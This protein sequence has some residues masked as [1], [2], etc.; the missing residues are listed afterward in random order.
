MTDGGRVY[1][2]LAFLIVTL[3]YLSAAGSE[4]FAF[5]K[6]KIAYDKFEW[7][8]YRSTHFEIYFY[9]EEEKALQKVV[10]FAESAYDDLA[11]KFNFQISDRIPLIYYAT[12]SD[13]EQ[14][15]VILMFIPEGVGAFAEPAKNRMVLPIDMPDEELLELITHELTH[16]FEYEIL[17]QGR[18]GREITN[19]LPTWMMEGLAS[20]MAQ[21]EDAKDR[22][23]LRDAVVNDVVPSITRDFGGYFAYRF[24]HAVFRFMVDEWGW[25]GLRDFIYESRNTLGS[26]IDRPLKRAFEITPEEFDTR[27]R[28]WLRRQYLPVLVSRGEPLEYG[29]RF[30]VEAQSQEVSPAPSPSGDLLAAMTTAHED[31]DVVLFNVPERKPMRNL[32]EGYAKEYEY[33]IAQM[34]TTGPVMGRDLAFSPT[35][36]QIAFFVKKEKGRNLMIMNALSGELM[37]S[38]SMDVEQQLNPA[39][40]PDGKKVVFHAFSG[41]QADLFLYDIETDRVVNLT[42]DA[43]FDAAPV[44]SPDGKWIYYSSVV[45][46]KAKIFRLDPASPAER[47]QLTRGAAND[48]D[49]YPSPDGKRIY[50]ASDRITARSA[51]E[52]DVRQRAAKATDRAGRARDEDD[53]E[54]E[55]GEKS[56]AADPENYAAFNIYSLDLESGKLLQFTD[57][58]GGAFTPVAFIGEGG[59]ERVVFTSYYKQRWDLYVADI[60]TPVAEVETVELPTAPL[61]DEERTP[62]LPPVEVAIDPEKLIAYDGFK[63]HIDDVQVQGGV[64]SD[65]TLLSR[66][67]IYMSDMLGSRRLIASLD[68]VDTFANFDFLYLDMQQRLNWGFRLFDDRT[69][70]TTFNADTERF[71]RQ[72]F[73]RQTAAI[74]LLSYP[75]DRYH[76][77]DFGGGFMVRDIDYPLGYDAGGELLYYRYNDEF[78]LA[79]ATFTGDSA[80]F[81]SFGP[82]AG[83]RYQITSTY[84]YDMDAG[85]TLSQDTVL[86]FRQYLQITSRSLLAFRVFGASSSGSFPNFYYFGGMDTLRG[87]DFRSIVGNRAFYTN[88]ELRFPLIDYLVTPGITLSQIR[89]SIFVDVGGA[90]FQGDDFTFM[91]DGKLVDGKA[92]F[93][94]GV[95]VNLFG[96]DLNWNF[97]RRTDLDEIGEGGF[98]TSFWIGQTF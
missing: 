44:F 56:S 46:G 69:Y 51:F 10:S 71:D 77:I 49:S 38:V 40:S 41:N 58:V 28:T 52:E 65:Q 97:A 11:R 36:D 62:F 19:R 29:E 34:L 85:G 73:Y 43:F 12:H 4:A 74:G 16:I 30:R 13:F 53:E 45:D 9:K 67:V 64:N 54:G 89:G 17:F 48:I 80:V 31:L 88:L 24:G 32:T 21:D 26:S 1:R 92:S 14:T 93:G 55:E 86:D 76:R 8:I 20:F 18:F 70:F 33:I 50:F 82:V 2:R 68:S 90:Y 60:D 42:N 63:L 61:R 22:M 79:S 5:G 84:G 91:D 3:L 72:R 37:K 59:R 81:K 15:N 87:Y 75:F 7:N 57:V 25:E 39:F 94:Y 35:G 27:F 23:V 98:E 66:S 96:L 47:F 6:N 83:R 78:P 95:S